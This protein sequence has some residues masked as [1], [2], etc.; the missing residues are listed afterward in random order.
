MLVLSSPSG[1]GKTTIS[2]GLLRAASANLR[3]SVSV[4]TRPKRPGEVRRRRLSLR[5]PRPTSTH[6]GQARRVARARQGVRATTT[7]RR[8][9]RSRRR[10]RPGRDV[11]F[12][13]DWQGTQQLAQTARD[14]LVSVFILPPSTR[15][16]EQR[17]H[18]PRPGPRRGGR[19]A[20]GQ[21]RRRD[22]P[23]GRIRLHHRQR[24]LEESV[25]QVRR[26]WRP[27]AC[28]ATARSASPT[29]SSGLREGQ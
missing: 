15:E 17:L 20:H 28:G 24:D 3:M 5:R 14:D 21:G 10:W 26:S 23:L 2:R 22:E 16:L 1:A 27:S 6:D 29:S 18:D 19:R 4:T 25:A 9:R 8:A 7:A 13:I 11:L 12:D